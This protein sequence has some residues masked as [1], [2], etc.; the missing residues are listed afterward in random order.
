[1][2]PEAKSHDFLSVVT[3]DSFTTNLCMSHKN[4]SN[5]ELRWPWSA[6]SNAADT[7]SRKKP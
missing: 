3:S 1:M 7:Q 4:F 5:Y 2:L 6:T